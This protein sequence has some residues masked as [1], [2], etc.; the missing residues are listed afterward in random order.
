MIWGPYTY[1]FVECSGLL[2]LLCGDIEILDFH[3][4]GKII[5][6]SLGDQFLNF[7]LYYVL[8]TFSHFPLWIHFWVSTCILL[9]FAIFFL[10]LS[11]SHCFS[12]LFFPFGFPFFSFWVL[13]YKFQWKKMVLLLSELLRMSFSRPLVAKQFYRENFSTDIIFIWFIILFFCCC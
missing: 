12:F 1:F 7:Q 4:L 3:P 10:F 13:V 5:W 9:S 8:F 2:D 11:H 6:L